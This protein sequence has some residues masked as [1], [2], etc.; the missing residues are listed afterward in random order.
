MR[1]FMRYTDDDIRAD[2]DRAI[3]R[4]GSIRKLAVKM[5]I[6]PAYLSSVMRGLKPVG[7]AVATYLGFEEDGKR[8][9]KSK[10]EGE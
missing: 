2:L 7:P 3:E 9:V 6:T 10:A 5:G 1:R 4:A 8:W